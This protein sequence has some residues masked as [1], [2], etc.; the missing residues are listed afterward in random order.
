MTTRGMATFSSTATTAADASAASA[1][2]VEEEIASIC[3]DARAAYRVLSRTDDHARTHALTKIASGLRAAS[4]DV[5]AANAA[6]LAAGRE[7][8]LSA[9]MLD[10][11]MLDA[12]RIEAMARGIEAVAALPDPLALPIDSW[13]T[14]RGLA[15]EQVRIPIGVVGVIYESRPNVTADV[16]ALCLK[17]ANAVILKGGKESI[18]SNDA[19]A[20]VIGD[21]LAACDLPRSCVQLVRSVERRATE[22]LLGHD[23]AIDVIIPRGGPGLVRAI[24]EHSRIPV[25]RHYEGIC[26][27]YVD[28]SA[29]LAMA[30]D[31]AFNAKVQRPGVCNAMENLLVHESVAREFFA[32][33]APRLLEAGVEL[34]GCPRTCALVPAAR[35]AT[36]DDWRTE[37]LDLVLAVRIVDSLDEAIDFV[38]ENGSGHSD[39]IVTRSRE[40]ADRFLREVDSAAVYENASTRFTDGFEFGFGAE[41][42]ISTNRLHAR[43]PMGLRELTTYKYVVRGQGHVR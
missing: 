5:T 2:T 41:V 10:R 4:A 43:G 12:H 14:S 24:A 22:A 9:A 20:R 37:Y 19:I 42:G 17:S 29:D 32:L 26:H 18:R 36:D 30:S 35:P 15:I 34:R 6:D 21:G 25:I 27:V 8:G 1:S 33:A 28:A 23:D 13:T 16:A 31:I 7:A 3:R 40:A 38:N 11:L 39:S